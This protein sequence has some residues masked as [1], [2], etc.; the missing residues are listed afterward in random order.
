MAEMILIQPYTG[1][2]DEMSIRL[3][4]GLLAVAAVPDAKGY[5]VKIIDQRVTNSFEQEL[6]EAVGPETKLIGLTAITGQ[7]IKYALNVTRTV[8]KLYPHVPLVWGGVHATLVPEQTASHPLV[9]FCVVGDG[10]LVFC[11]LFERLRDNKPIDDLRGLVYKTSV[12]DVKSNAGE[13]EIRSVASGDSYAVVRKN[14]AADVIRDLDTLPEL[15]YHLVP[16]DKY[17]VFCISIL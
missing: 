4:E 5:D 14:G 17:K 16:L 15:P 2:W 3:P 6:D 8:K 9:D 13:L 10:D 1:T 11:E 7:Q 12:G